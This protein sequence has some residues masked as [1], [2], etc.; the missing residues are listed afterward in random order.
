MKSKEGEGSLNFW[1]EKTS[2]LRSRQRRSTGR[3]GGRVGQWERRLEGGFKCVGNVQPYG[4]GARLIFE[5]KSRCNKTLTVIHVSAIFVVDFFKWRKDV[6]VMKAISEEW[7]EKERTIKPR[8]PWTEA[9][10]K[11][12]TPSNNSISNPLWSVP[13]FN[14]SNKNRDAQGTNQ[15]SFLFLPS[16]CRISEKMRRKFTLH[17]HTQPLGHGGTHSLRGLP[18]QGILWWWGTYGVKKIIKQHNDTSFPF[19]RRYSTAAAGCLFYM[20]PEATTE[21]D[22]RT[23]RVPSSPF[24]SPL[25]R[26]YTESAGFLC[27][28]TRETRLKTPTLRESIIITKLNVAAAAVPIEI[29]CLGARQTWCR[30]GVSTQIDH[31]P[32]KRMEF[33]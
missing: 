23:N 30:Q 21:S 18:T 31:T 22:W 12:K 25:S 17:Q 16:L 33:K 8:L 19:D 29:L 3:G 11:T 4:A 27:C 9:E 15:L 1:K 5:K 26:Q 2:F 10:K 13:I 6:D 32:S 24:P 28:T 7:R 20:W 14:G